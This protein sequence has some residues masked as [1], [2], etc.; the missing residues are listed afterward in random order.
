MDTLWARRAWKRRIVVPLRVLLKPEVLVEHDRE[1]FIVDLRD[2]VIARY[3]YDGQG[4]EEG[5]RRFVRCMDLARSVC[6]DVG[7]NL[8]LHTVSLA[9]RAA[10][11]W[12]FE[13]EERNHSL[14]TRN[15]A[16]NGLRNVRVFKCAVG[17]REGS[18]LLRRSVD[19]FGDHQVGT[20][21]SGDPTEVVPMTTI[22]LATREL[23]SGSVGLLKI[24]VQ[25]Y[26]HHVLIGAQETL[27]RNPDLTLILE[28]SP[29]HLSAAG[30]SA[31]ELV[32]WLFAQGFVGVEL[33]DDRM[34]PVSTPWAYD[35]M[36]S[37]Y[38]VDLVLSRNARQLGRSLASYWGRPIAD[39]EDG[40]E[41]PVP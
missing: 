32:R 17:D 29:T 6:V 11:V 15:V 9:K 3:L 40:R 30:R 5:L 7:A 39:L 1:A 23:P 14:L 35:F 12:A 16:L 2:T 20:S 4:Y 27:A 31:S 24:D 28:V 36:R 13:P 33:T 8:G 22:D 38:H 18:C 25:G 37:G 19:N 26:E 21:A 34:V 10:E 41:C